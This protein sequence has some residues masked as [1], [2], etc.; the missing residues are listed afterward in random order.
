[1]L[2]LYAVGSAPI[3]AAWFFLGSGWERLTA[4]GVAL[5]TASAVCGCFGTIFWFRAMESGTASVVSGFSAAYPVITVAAAVA[6]LGVSLVPVQIVAI[7]LLLIGAVVLGLHDHP[8]EAAVGRAW[9][10]PMLLAIILWGAWGIL[11]RMSID[12]LGFAGNSGI[13]VLVSTPIYLAVASMGLR[14]SG[15]W[16]RAGIREA[17]PSLFLFSIAGITIFLPFALGLGLTFSMTE[18]SIAGISPRAELRPFLLAFSMSYV[19]L[20]GLILAFAVMSPDPQI[21]SG[22]VLMAAVP[23]AIAVVPITSILR[24]DTRRA[25]IALALLYLLGLGLVPAITLVFTNQAAPFGE[26]VLQ[27]VLLIGVPLIASRFLRRFPR[28]VSFRGSGVSI[29]FFF[30]VV[31]TAGSTRGPLVAHPELI[32]SLAL[33]SFG[34][35]FLLGGVV[36]LLTRT[37][38]IPWADRVA[39]TTFSSFKNLGLTVVLA[40]AVFGSVATLPSIVSLVFEILWLAALPLLF[41]KEMSSAA[42]PA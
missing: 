22:W 14:E 27:T 28:V 29:S 2:V 18:I 16:D 12:S 11:E 17:I 15:S 39:V 4:V 30:L 3:Y 20:S 42:P 32:T 10:A 33:F 7:A 38:R 5:A 25:V 26:L 40:F 24:G 41:R 13:Y 35:T 37:L 1:M 9:L 36:F 8:G 6:I 21:R 31:A 34:R 19:V 23:P